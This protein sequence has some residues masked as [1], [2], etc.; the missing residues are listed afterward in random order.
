[1]AELIDPSNYQ[2]FTL[3]MLRTPEGITR[4]NGILRQLANNISGDTESVRIYQGVGT[5]EASVAAGVGSLYLRTDGGADTSVYRKESG[6]GDTGWVAIKAPASLP[7]ST[8]NGGLGADASAWTALDILYLSSTGVIGHRAL[9]STD[10]PAIAGSYTAG[11]YF[12]AGPSRFATMTSITSYTKIAE[13][14][15]PR[16]GS[17]RIKFS[18]AGNDGGVTTYGRIYR[19]GSAVGTERTQSGAGSLIDQSE[20][21]SG[22]TAGDLLQL[23]SKVSANSGT[24]QAGAL[25]IYE[26]TPVTEIFASGGLGKGSGNLTYKG[27][28]SPSTCLNSLGS[29]GDLYMYESGGAA[30]TLYVKTGASTWTAK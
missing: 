9:A 1:M 30:T 28:I 2:D 8:A 24:Q 23:Y 5:P 18:L 3:E 10:Y 29:I 4:L 27:D 20:D 17:L 25:K 26:G 12:I 19:N 11:N 16:S 15:I 21:I 13:M 7:L 14:Y 6:S 22:W